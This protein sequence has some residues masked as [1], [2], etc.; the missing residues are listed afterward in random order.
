LKLELDEKLPGSA[1]PRSAALGFEVDTVLDERLGGQSDDAVWAA[2]QRQ[3]GLLR[4]AL[5]SVCP[6]GSCENY[7]E[8][9]ALR[10]A[11]PDRD[12]RIAKATT[13]RVLLMGHG[14]TDKKQAE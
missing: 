3:D 5:C 2:A 7:K 9:A 4:R 12:S 8:L 13:C 6:N 1:A 14:A 11:L 10:G